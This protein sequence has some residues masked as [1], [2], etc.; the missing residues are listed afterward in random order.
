MT[1]SCPAV[2]HILILK[3]D[4]LCAEALRSVVVGVFPEAEVGEGRLLADA[5]LWLAATPIDLLV[6]GTTLLDGDTFDLLSP[7]DGS[8]RLPRRVLIVTGSRQPRMLQQL[9]ALPIAGI[10]DSSG[11]SASSLAVA[12]RRVAAGYAYFS[13]TVLDRFRTAQTSAHRICR[14]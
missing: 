5:R 13:Q 4:R 11:E 1:A 14:I 10:F 12:L 7:R 2:D 3:A 9:H 8:V 6:A